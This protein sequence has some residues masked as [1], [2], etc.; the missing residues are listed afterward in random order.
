MSENET[1]TEKVWPVTLTVTESRTFMAYV[2]AD[3]QAMAELYAGL[4]HVESE[5]VRGSDYLD[6]LAEGYGDLEMGVTVVPSKKIFGGPAVTVGFNG[7]GWADER[8]VNGCPVLDLPSAWK[9]R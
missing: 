9:D 5:P 6:E 3:S 4:I 2:A 7:E 1:R 8:E